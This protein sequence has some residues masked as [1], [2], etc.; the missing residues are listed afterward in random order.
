M[1]MTKRERQQF[2]IDLAKR[3]HSAGISG[4][5]ESNWVNSNVEA[6][7]RAMQQAAS[8]FHFLKES[9]IL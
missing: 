8:V 7:Q 9:E 2:K 4:G 6:R 1:S 5:M 3:I